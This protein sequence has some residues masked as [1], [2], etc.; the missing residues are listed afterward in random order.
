MVV[1]RLY[2]TMIQTLDK[3]TLSQLFDLY[4]RVVWSQAN[5]DP[6]Q[7]R[8]REIEAERKLIEA[9]ARRRDQATWIPA[10]KEVK[11]EVDGDIVFA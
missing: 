8:Y 3:L 4:G 7:R 6:G 10:T 2:S 9:E 1:N 5:C 11:R